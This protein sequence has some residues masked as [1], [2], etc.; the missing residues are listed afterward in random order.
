MQDA[1]LLT[2][3]EVAD[4]FHVAPGTVLAWARRGLIPSIKVGR[5]IRRFDRKLVVALLGER[6]GAE[7][8]RPQRTKIAV[9]V[10]KGGSP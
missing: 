6:L 2:T 8:D 4:I 7:P 5:K 1:R 3:R 10:R 9:R